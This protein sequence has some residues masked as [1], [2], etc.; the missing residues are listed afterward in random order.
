MSHAN[1][2]LTPKAR[3]K[4]GR[5]VIVD[6]WS[7]SM[8]A[9]RFEVSYRTA[10]RW[11][12][13]FAEVVAAGREPGLTDMRDRSS[14]PHRQPSRTPQRV[15]KRIVALRWRK[16]LGP[17]EIGHR[18]GLAPSTVHAVLRRWSLSRSLC[19]LI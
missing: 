11:A 10:Q 7:V 18:L 2:A 9:R 14:R 1:A 4:L 3:L 6:R 8:A 13:R 15:V 19:K 12:R 17:V 5:L 16:R